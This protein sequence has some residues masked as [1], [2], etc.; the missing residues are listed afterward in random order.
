VNEVT[1]IAP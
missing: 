1:W